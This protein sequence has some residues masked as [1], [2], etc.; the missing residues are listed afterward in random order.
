MRARR[1]RRRPGESIVGDLM[2]L[3]LGR[4]SESWKAVRAKKEVIDERSS[5]DDP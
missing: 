3:D 2:Q 5:D 4:D 1:S